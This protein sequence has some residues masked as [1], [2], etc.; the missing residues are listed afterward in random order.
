MI[1]FFVWPEAYCSKSNQSGLTIWPLGFAASAPAKAFNRKRYSQDASPINCMGLE[2]PNAVGL[3]AGLD[4][5]GD[6]IDALGAMGFGFVEIGTITPK[7]QSGNPQ[8]R[9]FRLKEHHALINRMGFNNLG[10]DH[11]VAKGRETAI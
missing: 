8:P 1:R 11:L 2:W 4:K 7:P 3:A 6:Y 5:N 9:L 10:V